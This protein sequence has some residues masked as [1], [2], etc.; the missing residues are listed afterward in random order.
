MAY[1][2]NKSGRFEIYLTEFPNSTST[3]QVSSEGGLRPE[4]GADDELFFLDPADTLMAASIETT[5]DDIRIADVRSLFRIDVRRH[6][7]WEPGHYA[8]AD[9]GRRF[10]VNRV[11]ERGTSA[12]VT[13]IV[14]WPEQLDDPD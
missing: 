7:L 10:L 14:G 12:P 9:E 2:S 5:G 3:W 1:A 4:W 11:L 6:L 8:V 13:L